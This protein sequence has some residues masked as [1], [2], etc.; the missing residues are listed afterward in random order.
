MYTDIDFKTKK[1]LK[2][3]V[4]RG[5]EVRVHQPGGL[6][7]PTTEGHIT[8]EGPHHPKAHTWYATATIK[9]SVL[10]KNSVK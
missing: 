8:L 10:V 6:F 4:A 2:E 3:A 1:A 9:D 7:K 5:Q